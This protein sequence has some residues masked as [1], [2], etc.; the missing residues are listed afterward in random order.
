VANEDGVPGAWDII[1]TFKKTHRDFVPMSNDEDFLTK[2]SKRD[3]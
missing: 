1:Q 2:S 3:L